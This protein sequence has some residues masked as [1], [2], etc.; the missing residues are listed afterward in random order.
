MPAPPTWCWARPREPSISTFADAARGRS[1][2]RTCWLGRLG[3]GRRERRGHDDLLVGAPRTTKG[4]AQRRVP[5]RGA[6]PVTGTLDLSFAVQLVG[7]QAAMRTTAACPVRGDVGRRRP[8]RP[9]VSRG[10]TLN[11]EGGRGAGAALL[12]AGPTTGDPRSGRSTDASSWERTARDDPAQVSGAGDVDGAPRRRAGSPRAS[13][14]A[15]PAPA[16]W[17]L[18]P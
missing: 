14:T 11:D 8:R 5:L 1:D 17:L 9:A 12:G 10:G 15:L 16:S 13:R 7:E 6:G 18:G 2:L 3:C 4:G